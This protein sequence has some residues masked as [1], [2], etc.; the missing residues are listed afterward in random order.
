[1]A[2]LRYA[3]LGDGPSDEALITVLDWLL[4]CHL[5]ATAVQGRWVDFAVLRSPPRS[6]ADRIVH[7][8]ETYV[9]DLL[10]V[11]VTPSANR[12]RH[13]WRRCDERRARPCAPSRQSW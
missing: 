5:P 10:F 12:T 2:E 4:K 1:M 3:L 7:A 8:A 11:I 6:L 9:F 13:V